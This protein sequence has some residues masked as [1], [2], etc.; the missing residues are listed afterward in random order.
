MEG[1]AIELGRLR[2]QLNRIEASLS[3]LVQQRTIQ[4]FYSTSEFAQIVDRAEFTVR[5]WCRNGRIRAEKRDAGRGECGEWKISHAE[6]LRYQ[7]HGLLP[8]PKLPI[9]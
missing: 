1:Q 8:D 2:E 7:S 5:E 3:L 4:D 6:L 9:P